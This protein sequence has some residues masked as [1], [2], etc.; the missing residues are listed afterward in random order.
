MLRENNLTYREKSS[1]LVDRKA[2]PTDAVPVALNIKSV[3]DLKVI[4]LVRK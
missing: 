1:A 3:K 4:S 2:I